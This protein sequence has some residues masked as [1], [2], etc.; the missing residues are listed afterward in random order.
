[1]PT[2]LRQLPSP[3]KDARVAGKLL[4]QVTI[5]FTVQNPCTML[6]KT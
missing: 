5:V 3:T 1:M 6:M 2:L 4:G